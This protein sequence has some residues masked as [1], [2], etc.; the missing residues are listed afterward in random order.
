MFPV[1][2][3]TVTHC[4]P[5]ADQVFGQ[6]V[7]TGVGGGD[8]V[9]RVAEVAGGA[10]SMPPIRGRPA[11]ADRDAGRASRRR[12]PRSRSRAGAPRRCRAARAADE[13]HR[14]PGDGRVLGGVQAH[15]AVERVVVLDIERQRQAG[16]VRP[17]QVLQA[18]VVEVIVGVVEAQDRE[19]FGGLKD[20]GDGHTRRGRIVDRGRRAAPGEALQL[21]VAARDRR[22][23]AVQ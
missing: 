9:S 23:A 22:C 19:V 3:S 14:V 6:C 7:S 16:E 5:V 20:A 17:R 18:Q 8:G 2:S 1:G 10:Q 13:R 4:I 12:R 15:R 11:D 21:E